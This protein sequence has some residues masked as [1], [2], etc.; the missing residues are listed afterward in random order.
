MALISPCSVCE[1]ET[2]HSVG[3]IPL[4]EVCNGNV[5]K[6]LREEKYWKMLSLEQR[7]EHLRQR[8]ECVE[9]NQR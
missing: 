2:S 4:C 9:Q 3:D 5:A 1:K 7:I 6:R 8:L